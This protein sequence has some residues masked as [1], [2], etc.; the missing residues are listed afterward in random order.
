MA[1]AH[2]GYRGSSRGAAGWAAWAAD[3]VVSSGIALLGT[4]VYRFPSDYGSIMVR[5][6]AALDRSH[7][8]TVSRARC[9]NTDREYD[10]RRLSAGA[11][12]GGLVSLA[13]LE[14]LER[15][16]E[17]FDAVGEHP[18]VLRCHGRSIE[19][20]GGVHHKLLLCDPC[21]MDLEARLQELQESGRLLPAKAAR[22]L[23]EQLAM[24][25]CHLHGQSIL[26]G[27]LTPGGV[28]LGADG[29]WKLGDLGHA[30]RLP[31]GA[32]D[33]RQQ[34][35]DAGGAPAFASAC[36]TPPEA[37]GSRDLDL[38]PEMDVWLLGHL[39]TLVLIGAAACSVLVDDGA[40]ALP[41]S[42]KALMDPL[43]ARFWLLLHW[44]LA[45]RPAQRPTAHEAMALLNAVAHMAPGELLEEMPQD[46]CE[47]C[48]RVAKAAARQLA[49][50]AVALLS[51]SASGSG[52]FRRQRCAELG[53]LSERSLP[54]LR[55]ALADPSD[56]D[57]MCENCGLHED[58]TSSP[59]PRGASD[60]QEAGGEVGRS[61]GLCG[62]HGVAGAAAN[63]AALAPGP[64]GG[65]LLAP[66]CRQGGPRNMTPATK[67][68]ASSAPCAEKHAPGEGRGVQADA[69]TNAGS[70]GDL[71][72]F[73]DASS[74]EEQDRRGAAAR[75]SI[76]DGAN[77][78]PVW[79]GNPFDEDSPFTA[80]DRDGDLFDNGRPF[81]AL[82]EPP[83]RPVGGREPSGSRNV[84]VHDLIDL[85]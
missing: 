73:D 52:E 82:D 25:L 74:G 18:H 42:P 3:R 63:G 19:N 49:I 81:R 34:C 51:P 66:P 38:A 48:T 5:E 55:A 45:P 2:A 79:D 65:A 83:Q 41:A 23:G 68:A 70:G 67:D 11:R 43:V 69:S 47:A 84:A 15:E 1:S 27:R 61:N 24:G 32:E 76:P 17:L 75:Q 64:S 14:A 4:G 33:W 59:R 77:A 37:R 28:L 16:A 10:L 71:L 72:S 6:E 36:E 35:R 7:G 39:L 12:E 58:G 50:D 30:S 20:V 8:A 57:R 13:A 62:E 60:L 22:D 56:V 21:T 26:L 85:G 29:C 9:L 53:Q 78:K 31:I 44:L 46:T 40:A 80:L 54:E